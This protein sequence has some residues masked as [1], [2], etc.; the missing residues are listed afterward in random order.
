MMVLEYF[1]QIILGVWE[2]I[3]V[4]FFSL[5]LGL[6]FGLSGALGE[7][8]KITW[9]RYVCIGLTSIIR[10]IP[11][12]LVIFLVYFGGSIA[13]AVLFGHYVNVSPFLAGVVALSLLFGA[14][15]AQVFRGAFAVI[16]TG[17][18]EA[19]RALG[20]T[21]WQIFRLIE[22]PQAWRYALPGIGNL[23]LILLKDTSLVSL[24]GLS[25]LMNKS[26]LAAS[27]THQPFTFYS[28]A[29]IIYLLLTSVSQLMLKYL[30][31]R[32]TLY[33]SKQD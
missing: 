32:A 16:P 7:A 2:T 19:G 27:T 33:L 28:I 11:E 21:R 31:R 17:Q 22:L 6:F 20:L 8:S 12:L 25:E 15:A 14:Y 30:A 18:A 13:L 26:Q 3:K 23:W 4:A 10:G 5:T 9:L 1:P 29:A 24:I